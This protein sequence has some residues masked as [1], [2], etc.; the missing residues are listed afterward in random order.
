MQM[1][2][3]AMCLLVGVCISSI[4][5]AEEKKELY[6][7]KDRAGITHFTDNPMQVPLKYRKESKRDMSRFRRSP[8]Q[9]KDQPNAEMKIVKLGSSSAWDNKCAKCHTIKRDGSKKVALGFLAIDQRTMFPKAVKDM[10]PRLKLL[11]DGRDG[12]AKVDVSKEELEEVA[13]YILAEQS[14]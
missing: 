14:K 8:S 4:A 5:Y 6:Q 1:L 3:Y 11:T 7:W 10:L 13:K 12:M 9:K 2:K